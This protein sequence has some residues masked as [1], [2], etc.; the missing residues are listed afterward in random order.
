MGR[1]GRNRAGRRGRAAR[2]QAGLPGLG[3][4]R[5]QHL[6]PPAD[7]PFHFQHAEKRLCRLSHLRK[8]DGHC[9]HPG[10][11]CPAGGRRHDRRAG[12]PRGHR[13]HDPVA[14]RRDARPGSPAAPARGDVCRGDRLGGDRPG[15][16]GPG[17][18]RPPRAHCLQ[19]RP[20]RQHAG[21]TGQGGR[22][23]RGAEDGAPYRSAGHCGVDRADPGRYALGQGAA[24][25]LRLADSAG[26]ARR[27]G[28]DYRRAL[29]G[30]RGRGA[31][32]GA[33]GPCRAAGQD[34]GGHDFRGLRL[35]RLPGHGHVGDDHGR[36]VA[37]G[38]PGGG[39]TPGPPRLGG[40]PPVCLRLRDGRTGGRA[41]S[42]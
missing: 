23:P 19:L 9:R 28:H 20:A 33:G 18:G 26:R 3:H 25:V 1:G 16:A 12:L 31:E 11:V 39:R 32:A 41:D 42:R 24:G 37:G 27:K 14:P 7:H 35:D 21:A 15:R 22:H 17:G 34:P 4:A 36:R 13:P 40:P 30:A 10:R 5:D 6:S 29:Q 38:G 8:G 2:D